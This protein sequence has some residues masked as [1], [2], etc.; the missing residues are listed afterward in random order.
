[1]ADVQGD[2]GA[3]VRVQVNGEA[4]EYPAPL[5]VAGLLAHLGLAGRPVAVECNKVIVR[6]A[7][8]ATTALADGDRL[9][10]VTFFG[11]G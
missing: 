10:V 5:T 7:E 4:R 3:L 1:M 9:E 2:A 11:G 6:K 8:H